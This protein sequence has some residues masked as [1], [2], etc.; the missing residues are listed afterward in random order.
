MNWWEAFALFVVTGM[1]TGTLACL[2]GYLPTVD[3]YACMCFI[4]SV[5]TWVMFGYS[6][7]KKEKPFKGIVLLFAWC[8]LNIMITLIA[9]SMIPI[10]QLQD[11]MTTINFE[12]I[13][14]TLMYMFLCLC[15]QQ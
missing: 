4:L 5:A 9:R 13:I 14:V 15:L 7:R 1:S 11:I 12:F 8:L 3:A 6:H 10:T 2:F